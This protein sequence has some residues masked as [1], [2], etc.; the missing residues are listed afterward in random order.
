MHTEVQIRESRHWFD[1]RR[2]AI[3]SA[4]RNAQALIEMGM[5]D[6]VAEVK[7]N[8]VEKARRY[9]A[10][11]KRCLVT[12]YSRVALFN[13]IPIDLGPGPIDTRGD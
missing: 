12:D 2:A 1:K 9:H 6:K 13:P 3:K 7:A 4:R 10:I 11:G 5:H 8:W